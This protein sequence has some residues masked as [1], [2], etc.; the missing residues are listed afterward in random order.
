MY[1]LMIADDQSIEC[2]AL[3]HKIKTEFENIEVLPSARDGIDFLKKA[4]ELKP[5]IVIA[6]INMPGLNG[7]ETI[8]ILKMRKVNMKVIIHTSYSEFDYARK[9]IQLGAVEYLLKP[10]SKEE[11]VAAINKVCKILDE[12]TKFKTK[13]S[14][15][16]KRE[17]QLAELAAGKWMMSLF[18]RQPDSESYQDFWEKYPQAAAGGV[19]TAWKPVSLEELKKNGWNWKKKEKTIL[20]QVRRYCNCVGM[21]HKDIFYLY[22]FPGKTP[23]EGYEEWIIEITDAVC[24]E[25]GEQQ[26]P[27]AVGIS[28]WKSDTQQYDTGLYE[29]RIAVQGKTKPGIS[30]FQYGEVITRKMMLSDIL[31]QVLQL[32]MENKTQECMELIQNQAT[33]EKKEISQEEME[34]FKVQAL[35]FILQL[36]KEAEN[37]AEQ[38][39]IKWETRIFTQDFGKLSCAD[40]ILGWIQAHIEEIGKALTQKAGEESEYIRKVLHYMKENFSRDL[41]LEDAGK[42]IGISSFYLSRLLKQERKTTFIE[43]LTEIRLSAAVNMMKEGQIP[44]KEICCQSGYPNQ[45]YFYR[46]VK[47]T[48]GMT[49]GV[50]R[51]YL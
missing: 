10:A 26:L 9:A 24:R 13:L 43:I 37:L 19:F 40:D 2:R 5:D 28:R 51:R 44:M 17:D 27:F 29:A 30:F 32:L 38:R 39:E 49:V 42:E 12:E 18:L 4:E 8:E 47:K 31:P 11:M 16:R 15:D 21:R 20:E 45:S 22:I 33:P 50:L 7:L 48:T 36:R 3:E 6:D 1:R 14:E 35:E 25:L 41:S 23:E 34:L 46:V